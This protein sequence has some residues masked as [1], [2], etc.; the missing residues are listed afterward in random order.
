MP[1]NAATGKVHKAG[2]AELSAWLCSPGRVVDGVPDKIL[3]WHSAC[4]YIH[5]RLNVC[6]VGPRRSAG[7]RSFRTLTATMREHAETNK[8]DQKDLQQQRG[9]VENSASHV[10]ELRMYAC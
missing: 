7:F 9:Y 5:H 4:A 1:P 2:V 10:Y 8:L 3:L 6:A